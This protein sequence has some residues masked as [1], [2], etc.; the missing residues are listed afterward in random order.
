VGPQ[1]EYVGRDDDDSMDNVEHPPSSPN[2]AQVKLNS[3]QHQIDEYPEELRTPPVALSCVV[4]YQEVHDLIAAHFHCQQPSMNTIGLPDFSKISVIPTR[5]PPGDNSEPVVFVIKRDH[6]TRIPAVVA[7]HFNSSNISGDPGQ[8]LQVCSDLENLKVTIPER[9][10]ILLVVCEAG[11]KDE[12]SEACMI[13][14]RKYTEVDSK[15]FFVF[16]PDDSLE[17]KSLSRLSTAF[18]DLENPYYRDEGRKIKM[19]LEKKCF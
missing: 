7:A 18:T 13:A 1:V 8:W 14:L 11:H 16:V 3:I 2:P 15:N 4:G 9:N 19:R 12:I 17:L 6:R 10:V 5:K